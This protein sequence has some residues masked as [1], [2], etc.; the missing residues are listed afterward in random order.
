MASAL[1]PCSFF[2]PSSLPKCNPLPKSYNVNRTSTTYT[3]TGLKVGW[4]LY[5][6]CRIWVED[7]I[8]VEGVGFLVLPVAVDGVGVDTVLLLQR[9]ADLVPG[10][11]FGFRV[12]VLGSSRPCT[13]CCGLRAWVSGWS[14]F[15]A[16]HTLFRVVC[17]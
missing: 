7:C 11:G 13:P 2:V 3:Y 5:L 1:T 4:K 15:K 16:L 9:L 17:V 14:F 6:R 10:F 12:W 8:R